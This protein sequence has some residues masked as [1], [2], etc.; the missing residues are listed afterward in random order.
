MFRKLSAPINIQ[1]ELTPW[2]NHSCLYCYNYWRNEK[3]ELSSELH[4]TSEQLETHT[5]AANEFISA[6]IFHV[7]LTGGEPLSVIEQFQDIIYPMKYAGITFDINSNLTLFTQQKAKILKNLGIT[8]ILTSLQ[9]ADQRIND[10]LAQQ[11]GAYS[12]TLKGIDLAVSCGFS[13]SINMVITKINLPTIRDTAILAKKLG[14]STFCATKA[15]SPFNCEDFEELE[16]NKYEFDQMLFDLLWVKD[17]LKINVETLEHYPSCAYPNDK[18]WALLGSRIC[19]A[20][21]TGC[22]V[23]FDGQLRPCSHA[24]VT[25]GNITNGLKAAWENMG[26]WRD[27]SLVPQIC[28]EKCIAFPR[29]CTGGCRIS[30]YIK[31]GCL[32]GMDPISDL[33]KLKIFHSQKEIINIP[34]D[35]TITLMSGVK[36]RAEEFGYIIYRNSYWLPI[37]N[38]LYSMLISL[39]NRSMNLDCVSMFLQVDKPQTVAIIQALAYKKLI[40]INAFDNGGK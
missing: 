6:G 26:G 11:E 5:K 17:T 35:S 31:E 16:I 21:K 15:N 22:T 19:S 12:R 36:F 37:D 32:T 3:Y 28:K 39:A 14:V 33:Q 8:R 1:W 20:G 9:S 40:K 38:K 7:T 23:G 25:Y 2:C 30:A 13:V 29:N 27:N 4:L 34:S 10:Y 24:H 18:T